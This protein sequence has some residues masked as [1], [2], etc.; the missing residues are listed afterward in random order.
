MASDSSDPTMGSTSGSTSAASDSQSGTS[1]GST[2]EMSTSP[3]GPET[4]PSTTNASDSSVPETGS[5]GLDCEENDCAACPPGST[6]NSYCD[7]DDF[8]CECVPNDSECNLEEVVCDMVE[9]AKVP[10]EDVV[11]CGTVTLQDTDQ[12]WQDMQHCITEASGEQLAYKGFAELQGF[13]SSVWA[14]YGSLVGF[15]YSEHIFNYDGGGL[16][17]GEFIDM[18]T[19]VP[20]PID[21]C[22]PVV[23]N[24]CFSCDSKDYNSV[25]SAPE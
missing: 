20:E 19:C 1:V 2:S 14:G 17:G 11:D 25:C 10:V 4:S 6:N 5:T 24:L 3:S 16:A 18:R 7:G 13:D 12:D 22:T 9:N 23:N 15:V 21:G 8:I